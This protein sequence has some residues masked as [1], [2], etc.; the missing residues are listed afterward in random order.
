[1]HCSFKIFGIPTV[2]L[3][4]ILG[5]ADDASLLHMDLLMEEQALLDLLKVLLSIKF[6]LIKDADLDFQKGA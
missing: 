3:L 5:N 1:M 6:V 4:R 2:K